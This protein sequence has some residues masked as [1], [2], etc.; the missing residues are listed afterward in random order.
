M[1][2]RRK[3]SDPPESSPWQRRM[4][5]A[6]LALGTMSTV[7]AIATGMFGLRD[8][9]IP[10]DTAT[11]ATDHDYTRAISRICDSANDAAADAPTRQ[12]RLAQRLARASTTIGQCNALLDAQRSILVRSQDR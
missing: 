10:R 11:A 1:P 3:R 8:A 6:T 2:R 7:V 12:R 4:S 5:R 9:V